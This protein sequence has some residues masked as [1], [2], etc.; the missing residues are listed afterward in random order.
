MQH[1]HSGP[2]HAGRHLSPAE[3]ARKLGVSAKAL[4]LYERHGLVKPVREANGYRTYGPAE[5]IRLHQV[6]A[7]KALGLPLSKISGLL[8]GR[9][10]SLDALLELQEHVL[11]RE[12]DRLGHALDLIRA[13][14]ARLAAGQTLSV[15]EL[16][17]LTKE[18]SMST[19]PNDEEMKALFEPH[20]A[21]HFTPEDRAA[22]QQP[23]D[24]AA[25]TAAWEAL[26]AEAK[27][28]MAKGDPTS[29]EALDLARR[30][31]AMVEQ[32]TGGDPA[33][34]GKLQH[35]W[36]DALNDPATAPKLPVD[37]ALMDF[38]M[39]AS[40]RLYWSGPGQPKAE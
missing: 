18:T 10:G 3:A 11:S 30:W 6:L 31:K 25:A 12:A 39:K 32:F 19:K 16:A 28:L 35:V 34:L 37:H 9:L 33:V 21:K 27:V 29:P 7:L 8:A 14:R 24:Q 4:R 2:A 26:I 15:D 23:Y 36:K 1:D 13:A 22:L 38:V 17:N 5:M 40:A 20:I